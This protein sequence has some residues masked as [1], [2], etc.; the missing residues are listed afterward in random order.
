[1]SNFKEAKNQKYI[2]QKEIPGWEEY[3]LGENLHTFKFA[4]RQKDGLT[5]GGAEHNI[6]PSTFAL[7]DKLIP[8]WND[9]LLI[10]K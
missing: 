3:E 9:N 1:M 10:K 8:S 4:K 2:K 6:F 5:K 7:L